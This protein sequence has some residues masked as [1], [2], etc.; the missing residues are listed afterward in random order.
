[1]SEPF[2]LFIYFFEIEQSYTCWKIEFNMTTA[3][4]ASIMQFAA[5]EVVGLF[6]IFSEN[7]SFCLLYVQTVQKP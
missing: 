3:C 6:N 4:F 7:L 5:V 2:V 1:M